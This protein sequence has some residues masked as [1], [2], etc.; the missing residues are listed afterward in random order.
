[1]L[2]RS[3]S[4]SRYEVAGEKW[5]LA[6]SFQN[7]TRARIFDEYGQVV[8]NFYGTSSMELNTSYVDANYIVVI[9]R[10]QNSS[11][12]DTC[13][14]TAS[15]VVEIF[16][17]AGLGDTIS[18]DFSK[19]GEY[20]SY[21]ISADIARQIVIANTGTDSEVR[22]RLVPATETYS[23]WNTFPDGNSGGYFNYLNAGE[24]S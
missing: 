5:V 18:G 1:M 15:R 14:F 21:R 4:Q 12:T 9:D 16:K 22:W 23:W 24:L 19:S 3:V 20:H 2:F 13:T 7:N 6:R 10:P 17:T 11:T 8:A